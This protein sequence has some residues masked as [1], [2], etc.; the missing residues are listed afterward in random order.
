MITEESHPKTWSAFSDWFRR[1]GWGADSIDNLSDRG[2]GEWFPDF[3]REYEVSSADEFE[4]KSD[5]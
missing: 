2:W 4:S 5:E 3:L 1:E